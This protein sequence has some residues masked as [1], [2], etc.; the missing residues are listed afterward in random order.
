MAVDERTLCNLLQSRISLGAVW[1]RAEVG[2]KGKPRLGQR[3]PSPFNL[4]PA[5]FDGLCP[6]PNRP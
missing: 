1:E 6:F 3:R 2:V 4:S 5:G